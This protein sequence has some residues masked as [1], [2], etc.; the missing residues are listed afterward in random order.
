[1]RTLILVVAAFTAA[2]SQPPADKD[3][4]LRK[5]VGSWDLVKYESFDQNGNPGGA[6]YD[7]G[8]IMYD[9]RGHMSAQLSRKGRPRV[10]RQSSS[11]D[12]LA[13]AAGYLAYYGTYEV[14]TS[15]QIVTHHVIG[16]T[17]T[18][19]EGTDLIR[20]YEFAADGTLV[21]TVKTGDRVSAKL[22]WRHS[23]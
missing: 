15:K 3:A 23:P 21:L 12:R 7:A 14:D 16:S 11:D 17:L 6:T 1:M 2:A 18:S 13:A 10:T 19:W 20:S 9:E 5:L 8:R 4:V 22:S